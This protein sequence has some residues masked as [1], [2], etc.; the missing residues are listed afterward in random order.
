MRMAV[1][2]VSGFSTVVPLTSGAEPAAWKPIIRGKIL[3]RP[4]RLYSLNPIQ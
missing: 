3:L 4:A 2:M 1:A